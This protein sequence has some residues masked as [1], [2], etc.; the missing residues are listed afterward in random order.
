MNFDV[1]VV[2]F[3]FK[4]KDTVFRI[5]DVISKIKPSKIYLLSD[6]GRNKEEHNIVLDVRSSIENY[7]NWDCEIIKKY[8]EKNIGV[9]HNIGGGAKWVLEREESAIFLEDDNLP[10]ISFFRFCE[11]MLVKYK[12]NDN[13]LWVVGT[14]YLSE[15]SPSDDASYMFTKHMLP[16]GWASWS[17]KFSKFYDGKLELL[18]KKSAKD[19]K[20]S[21]LN[22]K[23]YKQE[24]LKYFKTKYTLENSINLASW[25]AQ[26]GFSLR[27]HG[28]YGISP[29]FNQIKNIG[30]DQYSTH[31]GSSFD[32]PL[33]QRF[34]ELKTLE[35]SFPLNHPNQ[36]SIDEEYEKKI[37]KIVLYPFKERLKIFIMS[38]VKPILGI[39]KHESF[40]HYLKKLKS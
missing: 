25:D 11:E 30:V 36:I 14:N 39:D 1:P 3:L 34:C 23:L 18:N 27:Y 2:L 37:S 24:I 29:K 31:G 16:C 10:E 33:T 38:F 12:N 32:N 20:A 5:L 4:R 28:L 9:Y 21:F 19:L 17:S 40:V 26:I 7:I 35:L 6:G 22:K 8:A 13:I 15:Y